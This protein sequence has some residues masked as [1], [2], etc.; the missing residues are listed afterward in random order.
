MSPNSETFSTLT[1][2]VAIALL[3]AFVL[4]GRLFRDAWKTRGPYWRLKCSIYGVL[5]LVGFLA[6]AFIPLQGV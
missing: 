6:I 1:P 3:I 5:A 2:A 4:C